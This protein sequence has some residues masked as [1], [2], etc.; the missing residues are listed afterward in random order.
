MMA[1]DEKDLIVYQ[2]PKHKVKTK[3]AKNI[4]TVFFNI[5]GT[6]ALDYVL[7]W[8]AYLKNNKGYKLTDP[9]FPM[10]KVENGKQNIS[11]QSTG[12]VVPLFWKTTNASRIIF[13][14]RF[15]DA[16][17]PYYNPHSL[18]HLIVKEISK[19]VSTE[20]QK[21]AV[22]QNIGHSHVGTT[23]GSYGEGKMDESRM[24]EIVRKIKIGGKETGKKSQITQEELDDAL[25]IAEAIKRKRENT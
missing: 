13:K 10:T 19:T 8:H 14:K 24:I 7:D 25:L 6:K 1:F 3:F 21:K 16:G 20:E 9:L 2:N 18:R 15:I 17:I 23:F 5:E 11:Y 12:E 22:S 4:D